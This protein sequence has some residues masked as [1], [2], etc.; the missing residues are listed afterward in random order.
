MLLFELLSGTGGPFGHALASQGREVV[1]LDSDPKTAATIHED[2]SIWDY[3][4]YPT[5]H[6]DTIW[7]SPCCALAPAAAPKHP[8]IWGGRIRLCSERAKAQIILT[9]GRGF[10]K[11]TKQRCEKTACLSTLCPTPMLTNVGIAC[12]AIVRKSACETTLISSGSCA[13][14]GAFVQTWM[15]TN[16]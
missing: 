9:H 2:I 7:V 3:T 14:V 8:A 1:P 4:I 15:A 11:H 10:S 5:G 12:G 13:S 6:F 16:T